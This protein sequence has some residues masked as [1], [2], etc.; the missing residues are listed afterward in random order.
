MRKISSLVN[1]RMHEHICNCGVQLYA[2]YLG[3]MSVSLIVSMVSIITIQEPLE[4]ISMFIYRLF[5][6]NILN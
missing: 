1:L 4:R 3:Y 2:L 5:L 6:Y